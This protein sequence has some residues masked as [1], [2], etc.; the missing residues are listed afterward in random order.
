MKAISQSHLGRRRG[1]TSLTLTLT[2][3]LTSEG[4]E[5]RVEAPTLRGQRV[6]ARVV[7]ERLVGIV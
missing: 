2:L 3:T 1:P 4:S 5:D 7:G 6:I